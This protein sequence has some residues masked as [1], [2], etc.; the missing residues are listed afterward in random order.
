MGL[1]A[2]FYG[3]LYAPICALAA[4]TVTKFSVERVRNATRGV[5]LVF[6]QATSCALHRKNDLGVNQKI[7]LVTLTNMKTPSKMRL[8]RD[9][10]SN[11]NIIPLP[12][13]D[14]SRHQ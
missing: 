6:V 14:V 2:H 4:C 10:F 8:A 12:E 7:S 11:D 9:I 13:S 3:W 5:Q 1:T